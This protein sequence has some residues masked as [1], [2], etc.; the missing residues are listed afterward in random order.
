[1]HV[2]TLG[3]ESY[4]Q[5][6]SGGRSSSSGAAGGASATGAI[7]GHQTSGDGGQQVTHPARPRSEPGGERSYSARH[8]E[9]RGGRGGYSG[10]GGSHGGRGRGE[11]HHSD[12]DHF[13]RWSAGGH[14]GVDSS[15]G[16][17]RGGRGAAHRGGRAAGSSMGAGRG[18]SYQA[19]AT[20]QRSNSAGILHTAAAHTGGYYYTHT[21]QAIYYPPPA[22]APNAVSPDALKES[23]KKQMEYYFSVEN[24][25]RD[26]FLR[27]KMDTQGWIPLTTVAGF[28]RVRMLTPDLVVVTEALAGSTVVEFSPDLLRIRAKESPQQW[29]LPGAVEAGAAAASSSGS[30]AG[31]GAAAGGGSGETEAKAGEGA[32]SSS[33]SQQQQGGEQS[34]S[35]SGKE[36]SPSGSSKL[37]S[38]AVVFAFPSK[39]TVAAAAVAAGS[40]PQIRVVGSPGK[41]AARGAAERAAVDNEPA[42]PVLGKKPVASVGVGAMLGQQLFAGGSGGSPVAAAAAAGGDEELELHEEDLFEMDEDREEVKETGDVMTD[43]EVAKLI[44]VTSGKKVPKGRF[45]DSLINDGLALYQQELSSASK[46]KRGDR[47]GDR[48]DKGGDHHHGKEHVGGR[49]PR[50]PHGSM[51]KQHGFFPSSYSRSSGRVGSYSNRQGLL[52]ESPPSNHV[53]W[54]MGTTPPELNGLYGSS[55]L[56][57]GSGGR[58]SGG[59]GSW[60]QHAGVLGSSPRGHSAASLGTS[61]P[62]P[63]IQHPSHA[64][65]EENGFRQMKYFKYHKRCIEER[66]AKGIGQSEEMNTLFRFWCYFLRNR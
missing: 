3:A 2:A 54:L 34:T 27:G 59:V 41:P 20:V 48:G 35:S 46:G 58:R 47:R 30:A 61:Q 62:L 11:H 60:G 53:G 21:G 6:Q 40:S 23:V 37:N 25:T 65:L 44:V 32:S 14:G 39:A 42:T 1:M 64:L 31:A 4:S 38:D 49:P 55:P 10:R 16:R 7:G 24:L 36:A 19:M 9:S 63:K 5:Q 13:G 28:N 8:H 52:G 45:D 33:S 22:L 29:V 50:G 12:R 26:F 43:H 17:G 18:D 56:G 15:G 51:P 57:G 66:A